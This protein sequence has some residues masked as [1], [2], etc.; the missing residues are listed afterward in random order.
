[1]RHKSRKPKLIKLYGIMCHAKKWE[2]VG[3]CNTEVGKKLK[4][5]INHLENTINNLKENELNNQS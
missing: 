2:K 4:L 1:M 3:N 5:Q